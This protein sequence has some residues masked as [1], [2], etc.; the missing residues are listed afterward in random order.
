MVAEVAAQQSRG[1][2][3]GNWENPISREKSG[4]IIGN[5]R[6]PS[7]KDVLSRS[8]GEAVA[9]APWPGHNLYLVQYNK[10]PLPA[11]S[12][13]LCIFTSFSWCFLGERCLARDLIT[14][15]TSFHAHVF[16]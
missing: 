13:Y 16:R 6:A 14:G 12:R 9:E 8:P 4:E 5:R 15:Q 7:A 2:W 10:Y 11:P 3:T 1:G